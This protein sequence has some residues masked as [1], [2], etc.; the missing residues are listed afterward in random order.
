MDIGKF[1]VDLY[2]KHSNNLTEIL[3]N[4]IPKALEKQGLIIKGGKIVHKST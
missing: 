3:Y 1:I 4:S 2:T